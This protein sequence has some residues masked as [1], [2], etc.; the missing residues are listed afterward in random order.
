MLVKLH[1]AR[2]ARAVKVL[3]RVQHTALLAE[4]TN[5][6]CSSKQLRQVGSN[7][8][9]SLHHEGTEDKCHSVLAEPAQETEKT[10]GSCS[11][12]KPGRCWL[13]VMC[14]Q[15]TAGDG[16]NTA[17]ARA[18]PASA[19]AQAACADN[20]ASMLVWEAGSRRKQQTQIHL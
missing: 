11:A 4:P 14:S 10:A 1:A 18:E 20:E 9:A 3:Q 12:G 8:A 16:P 7:T 6:G 5:T 15:R 17:Q 13:E 2:L 19:R